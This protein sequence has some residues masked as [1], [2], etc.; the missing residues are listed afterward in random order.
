MARRAPEGLIQVRQLQHDGNEHAAVISSLLDQSVLKRL[1]YYPRTA[2]ALSYARAHF[3]NAPRLEM[4]ASYVGMS[5]ASFS[6]YFADKIGIPFFEVLRILRIERAVEELERHECSI[7]LLACH[8]GY[9]SA[10]TFTRAFKE[11]L[12]ETPSEYRRRLLS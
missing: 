2:R 9:S 7:E 10:C 6:R 12:G 4:V 1:A 11:I 3:P 5:T 8:S